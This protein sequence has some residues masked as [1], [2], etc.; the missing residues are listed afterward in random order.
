M[1]SHTLAQLA[2]V[3]VLVLLVSTTVFAR[4]VIQPFDGEPVPGPPTMIIGE[5]N[6][7]DGSIWIEDRFEFEGAHEREHYIPIVIPYYDTINEPMNEIDRIEPQPFDGEP[8][9]FFPG[10]IGTS[11]AKNERKARLPIFMERNGGQ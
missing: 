6:Y 8:G 10:L 5:R 2:L 3:L 7:E 9:P 11:R 1:K 4:K